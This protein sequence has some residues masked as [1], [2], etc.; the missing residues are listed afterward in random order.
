MPH[1]PMKDGPITVVRFDGDRGEYQMA[2]GEGDSMPG[3]DTLNNYVWMKVK[4]WPQWERTLIQGPF[5][6]HMAMIYGHYGEA[7]KEAMRYMPG[8][9]LAPL[10]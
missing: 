6:H 7:I 4:N 10:E 8:I 1:F 9:S 3:P 5:I 2:V